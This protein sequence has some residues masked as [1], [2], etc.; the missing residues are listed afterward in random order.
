MN[1]M[2]LHVMFMVKGSH[3]LPKKSNEVIT[4]EQK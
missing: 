4:K 2:K 1:F 3:K